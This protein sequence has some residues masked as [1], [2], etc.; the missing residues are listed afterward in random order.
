M[1]PSSLHGDVET[2]R[3]IAQKNL[4]ALAPAARAGWPI[5]CSEPSAALMLKHDYLDLQND[6]DARA[7]AEVWLGDGGRTP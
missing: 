4:R 1:A 2:A 3:E 6:D 7:V 5:V